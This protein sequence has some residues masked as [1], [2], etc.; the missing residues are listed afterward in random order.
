MPVVTPRRASMVT[1]NAVPK[2][3]R[4]AARP[5][6]LQRQLERVGLL[7][8]ERQADQAA[9]VLGHEVDGLGRDLLGGHG[10]VALVLA[11][12]VVDEDDHLA[13]AD[14][15]ERIAARAAIALRC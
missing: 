10:Q 11:V 9:A 12:L 4:R 7:L 6:A 2:G 8:G 14:V 5:A 15:V 1:V 13:G 3:G